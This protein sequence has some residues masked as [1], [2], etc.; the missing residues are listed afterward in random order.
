MRMELLLVV[1]HLL[2]VVPA[3]FDGN[4][5]RFLLIVQWVR[6]DDFPLKRWDGEQQGLRGF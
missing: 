6:G 2:N 5:S 4:L 1:F 3:F